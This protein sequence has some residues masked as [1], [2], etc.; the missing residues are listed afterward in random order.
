MIYTLYWHPLARIPGP[1][2]WILSRL[3]YVLALRKGRLALRLK[4]IH[5]TY[6]VVVRLA[7]N[8]V[9]FTDERA[10]ASIYAYGQSPQF[11]KSPLWY[12]MRPNGAYG[13]M[14]SPN[15]EHGRFRRTFA[16]AFTERAVREQQPLILRHIGILIDQLKK[17]ANST[18]PIDIVAWFEYV[19]FDIIGDLSYSQS[20]HCLENDE[21]HIQIN[22]VQNA[23]KGFTHAV[24]PRVLGLE[25]LWRLT[26]PWFSTQKRKAYY[27][28]LNDWTHQRLAEGE[29]N[30]SN[31]FMRYAKLRKDGK[32]LSLAETE[33]AIGDMMIAGSETV[34]STLAAVFYQL[35]KHPKILHIVTKEVR[36]A[37]ED[38]MEMSMETVATL[39]LLNAVISE[40]MR[41]C[42]SL[43]MVLPR[44]VPEPGANICGY[45]LPTGVRFLK[46]TSEN[47]LSLN[48]FPDPCKLLPAS[49]IYIS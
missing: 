44:I 8:E 16:P 15:A 13:I 34:A 18:V 39:P 19:A 12:R 3:P 5:E 29:V 38:K 6:G 17:K 41:L 14:S 32:G 48:I 20:F 31:D 45:W 10:W 9:S 49:R 4:E 43:P 27:K 22:T 23:M 30:D 47:I 42:P 26:V 46:S 35:I 2:L 21:N 7:N 40:A 11:P 1:K 25:M 37:F 36:E 24:V 28:T 33:N